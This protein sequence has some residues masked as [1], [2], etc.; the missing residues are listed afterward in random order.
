MGAL[1]PG[2][3]ETIVEKISFNVYARG[4]SLR[5]GRWGAPMPWTQRASFALSACYLII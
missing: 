2:P 3:D 4:V 5:I 1:L